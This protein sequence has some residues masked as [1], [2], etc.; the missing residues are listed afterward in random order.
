M[1]FFDIVVLLII[2][3]S[4]AYSA[5]RGL[6]REL[7]SFLGLVL[8]YVVG[9]NFREDLADTLLKPIGNDTVA[10]IIGFFLLFSA[11]YLVLFLLGRLLKRYVEKSEGITSLDRIWG[12]VIGAAKGILLV[13]ILLFPLR[14]FGE[15]YD[16]WT[17]DSA[18]HP[19]LHDLMEVL[20]DNSDLP[21]EYI[22]KLNKTDLKGT[23]QKTVDGVKGIGKNLER[24]VESGKEKKR[25]VMESQEKIQEVFTREDKKKLQEMLEN[26]D[27][28]NSNNGS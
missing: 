6:I 19:R 8:G 22:D 18:L 2:L 12:G 14:F 9:L 26:M 17:D 3:V 23:I 10:E 27:D 16:S 11:T 28:N 20:G 4:L 13:V 25:K 21:K 5:Y 1:T 15:T 24:A 7:F